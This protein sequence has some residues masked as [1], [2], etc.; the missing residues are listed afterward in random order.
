MHDRFCRS[1]LMLLLVLVF[2]L[3]PC[4]MKK[5]MWWKQNSR[6]LNVNLAVYLLQVLVKWWK[7]T[8]TFW[9]AKLNTTIRVENTKN[10]LNS[11]PC[12]LVAFLFHCCLHSYDNLFFFQVTW[13]GPF[14]FKMHISAFGCCNGAWAFQWSLSFVMQFSERLSS[15]VSIYLNNWPINYIWEFVVHGPIRQDSTD[16]HLGSYFH[17]CIKQFET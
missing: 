16:L 2:F 8:L 6:N 13:K 11:H 4:S 14:S 5:N 9:L 7:T 10:V 15:K 1:L 3:L 17:L 12:K